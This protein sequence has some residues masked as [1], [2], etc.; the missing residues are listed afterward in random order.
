MSLELFQH[1]ARSSAETSSPEP[2]FCPGAVGIKTDVLCIQK[3]EEDGCFDEE[4]DSGFGDWRGWVRDVKIMD[5]TAGGVHPQQLIQSLCWKNQRFHGLRNY[6]EVV[7]TSVWVGQD[8]PLLRVNYLPSPQAWL[9][10]TRPGGASV[11]S[12][13]EPPARRQ[14]SLTPTQTSDQ[15][16]LK[17][18]LDETT[19]S[20]TPARGSTAC[21]SLLRMEDGAPCLGG[22]GAFVLEDGSGV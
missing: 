19:R 17:E 18:V 14:V 7:K 22:S 10:Q 3:W 21:S 15:Q 12:W 9:T 13:E 4:A 20:T 16:P 2:R 1:E 6:A 11:L 5:G 8:F